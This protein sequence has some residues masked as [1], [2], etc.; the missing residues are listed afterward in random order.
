MQHRKPIYNAFLVC[1][2]T[3]LLLCGCRAQV[4]EKLCVLPDR[5]TQLTG[6]SENEAV[7]YSSRVWDI[8]NL[9]EISLPVTD[10]VYYESSEGIAHFDDQGALRVSQIL[11]GENDE[12]KS[13][14][15]E[16]TSDALFEYTTLQLSSSV[17]TPL[18]G[19][20]LPAPD[21]YHQHYISHNDQFVLYDV[22]E[23][24]TLFLYLLNIATE[25][26]RLIWQSSDL[27]DTLNAGL[28]VHIF[29]QWAEDDSSFFFMPIFSITDDLYDGYV[30]ITKD[31][32]ANINGASLSSELLFDFGLSMDDTYAYLYQMASEGLTSYYIGEHFPL[33][34]FN[35]QPSAVSNA[36]GTRFF[37]YFN[38]PQEPSLAYHIDLQ[39]GINY[40]FSLNDYLPAEINTLDLHP[41]FYKDI[42][43]LYAS[44]IGIFAFD[45]DAG[46]VLQHY[47]FND[48][49]QAFVI[50]EDT[51]IAAQSSDTSSSG[52]DVTAYLLNQDMQ[53]SVLLYHT[54]SLDP[55]ILYMHVDESG[56]SLRLLIE[57]TT[58][59]AGEF[60]KLI[61]LNF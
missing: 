26:T 49:V 3:A 22:L 25:E 34:L 12:A 58:S 15:V 5:E 36:D 13:P 48:P 60:R 54:D 18:Q 1:I 10:A 2:C 53:Q 45:M 35:A 46:T 20:S 41:V 7:P 51:L 8:Q 6:V 23:D 30:E 47:H 33:Y 52:V 38:S 21:G 24:N 44:G 27:T 39:N 16:S 9:E 14:D 28:T 31:S 29:C 19:F 32:A 57:I 56:D 40:S 37:I 50:C 61:L 4:V 55:Y 42:L 17:Q 43:Y 11:I 59:Q